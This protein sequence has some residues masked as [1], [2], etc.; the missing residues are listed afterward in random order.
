MTAQDLKNAILQL[1]VQGKLVPQ[2]PADEPASELLK[3]IQVE[4]SQLAKE[5]KRKK[6]KP[7]Q[8]I[9]EDECPFDIPESW[10]WVRLGDCSSYA[11]KKE[12]A[13]KNTIAPD[14]WS[15]DLEDIEKGTGR[16]VRKCLFRDRNIS[17]ERVMFQKGQILYSKLRPYLKKVLVAPNDGVCSSEIVPFS[18]YAGINTQYMTY[19]LTTP[20]IDFVI[21]SVTY[22]TKMPRVGTDTMTNLLIPLPPLTEQARI[23]AKIEELLPYIEE[24]DAAEKRLTA[25]DMKFPDQLRKSILQ[26]AI[27][28]KL[29]ERDPADEPAS[30]L[31]KRIQTEKMRLIKEGKLKKGKPSSP[32]TEDDVPFEIPEGW[33]W[34]R[35]SDLMLSFSTGPFGTM[36][37]K[38]DYVQDGIPLVNPANIVGKSIVPSK[39]MMVSADTAERL[40]A[41]RLE[42]GMLVM[43][44]RGEMGRCA[45]VS[46]RQAGWLCGTGS[47]FMRPATSL[48]A[49]YLLLFFSTSYARKYLEGESIGST[50]NNLNHKILMRIPV[51]LPSLAEQQR[52]VERVEELLALCGQLR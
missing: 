50:M 17:G 14:T 28:G 13:D 19:V 38:S 42:S 34:A 22:G 41:Y 36:L 3:R 46:E 29:T 9:F 6:V 20:H 8:P 1:A 49:D 32:I 35:F 48:C 39:K 4:K 37:H 52:I 15:L 30:E 24:Y 43:G 7:I 44:R 47:F 45:V 16:I 21:N 10:A 51:P 26:Q 23:V 33:E 11:Q 27:M 25:L 18:V 5:G 31:L 2:D 12:K 40:N